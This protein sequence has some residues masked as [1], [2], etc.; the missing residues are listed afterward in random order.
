MKRILILIVVTMLSV[1]VFAQEKQVNQDSMSVKDSLLFDYLGAYRRQLQD[2]CYELYPTENNWTFLKLN[3]ATGQI[4]QV[5]YSIDGPN[6]RFETGLDTYDRVF[7]NVYICGRFELH[8]TKNM[9]NFILLDKLNGRC[10]QVQWSTKS[11]ERGVWR[12]Y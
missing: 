10:W 1:E 2:P 3:T 11:D 9:Y 12:I 4:W 8:K 5:Q 7:D 6:Y